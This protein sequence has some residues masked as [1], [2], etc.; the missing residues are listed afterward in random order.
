MKCNKC[1]VNEVPPHRQTKC[2]ACAKIDKALWD[3][4][5]QHLGDID[6]GG[7]TMPYV[8][9]QP[10]PTN[11][12][13]PANPVKE[14]EPEIKKPTGEYQSLVYNKTLSANSFEVGKAGG[15]FKFYFETIGELKA[16][17]KEAVDAKL[18]V[19]FVLDDPFKPE[20]VTPD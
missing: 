19:E 1:N 9:T 12:T 20:R 13:N 18:M 6:V 7:R 3:S 11:P 4:K 2:D 17:I 5:N 8:P 10:V 14:V 16:K 15:R